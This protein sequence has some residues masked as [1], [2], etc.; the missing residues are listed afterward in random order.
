[1]S[2]PSTYFDSGA[3]WLT[4]RRLRAHA[5]VLA[6][7]L[8]GVCAID[9]ATPGLFDRAGNIKFQDFIQ[10]PIA[11]QLIA[12]G[13]APELYN[14]QV[15]ANGI[16]A[17]V[18]RDTHVYLEYF[19]GPQVALPFIPLLRLSFLT[20]AEIWVTLSAILYFGCVYLLWRACPSLRPFAALVSICALAYPSLFHFFVR[21]QLSAIVLV[22][23][24]AAGLAFLARH[25]WVAGIALG[26]LAFKPQF[27]AG[28][29]LVLLLAQAWKAFV[30]LAVS[31][32]AQLAF[33]YIYFGPS[34][35]R[36][37][38]AMLLHSASQPGTT[39][40]TLSPIQMHSLRAFWSLLIPW[41]RGVWLFYILSTLAVVGIAAAIWRSS[42]PPALRFSAL[43]LAS[44]LVSPHLYIYDLLA[45]LPALLLLADWSLNH[46]QHPC[47]PALRCLLYLA[48]VLPLFGPVSRWTHIQ[49][50]VPAFVALLWL[51]WRVSRRP[52]TGTAEP[53]TMGHKFATNESPVV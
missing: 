14:D 32:S 27:L 3:R 12:Q 38:L 25:D 17:I 22:C 51:L 36:A 2:K 50:S 43:I 21:G 10:F 1:M 9:F 37:Y 49:L 31:A 35:M 30:G 48:F 6:L 19:Y 52:D 5:T 47:T 23:F 20:Q 28:I 13:R 53:G 33:T 40:L 26:V 42:S 18:G 34:V 15:L 7:C 29:I 44:V 11:A 45:L 16:R 39:E 8:W 4:P 46:A 24:T 41:P